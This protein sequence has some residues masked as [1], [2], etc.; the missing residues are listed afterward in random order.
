MSIARLRRC[1]RFPRVPCIKAR[2]HEHTVAGCKCRQQASVKKDRSDWARVSTYGPHLRATRSAP[3]QH[4]STGI[5]C[6]Q[7]DSRERL[8]GVARVTFCVSGWHVSITCRRK[9]MH[10]RA[11]RCA[12]TLLERRSSAHSVPS[13]TPADRGQRP[14]AMAVT[15][16]P[17]AQRTASSS[18]GVVRLNGAPLR[19]PPD[20]TTSCTAAVPSALPLATTSM[21]PLRRWRTCLHFC[22]PF[23]TWR[24]PSA[25]VATQSTASSCV[26]RRETTSR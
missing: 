1:R 5:A 20:T 3:S 9:R 8:S 18:L 15:G 4:P 16:V 23:A 22:V 25:C 17:T 7:H 14:S 13:T 21:A 6:D 2:V 24:S 11:R 12:R 26:S 10:A 19:S